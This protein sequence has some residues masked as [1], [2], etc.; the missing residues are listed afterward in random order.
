MLLC[1]K[2]LI[3][4]KFLNIKIMK[5]HVALLIIFFCTISFVANSQ[6]LKIIQLPFVTIKDTTIKPILDSVV[7]FE[8]KCD[9]YND[10]TIFVINVFPQ[11]QDLYS[12]Q[13]S[14]TNELN[15]AMYFANNVLGCFYYQDHLFVVFDDDNKL[16]KK[17]NKKSDIE[18]L[19][20]NFSTNKNRPKIT[21]KAKDEGRTNWHYTYAN[22]KFI[23]NSKISQ[24][25]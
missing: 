16:F 2:N 10:S 18:Y 1:K 3:L 5:K 6:D 12:I 4:H 7:T 9:Y 19:Q 23:Y 11:N 8:K 13:I 14:S 20:F 17:T 22:N 24:C 21:V 25:K 15:Y